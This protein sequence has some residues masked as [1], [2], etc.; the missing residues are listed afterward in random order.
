MRKL[1]PALCCLFAMA[2]AALAGEVTLLKFDKSAK[3]I[4]VKEGG[5]EKT[6][7]VTDRTK[8]VA[9]DKKSGESIS[10]TYEDAAK[11]LG[12]PKAAGKLKFDLTAK[13]DEVV[14][15]KLPGRKKK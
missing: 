5:G 10:L 1:L 3:Q 7:K 13:G 9:V 6:Y 2:G 4:T 15:A 8:F 12:N 14:E 11:G